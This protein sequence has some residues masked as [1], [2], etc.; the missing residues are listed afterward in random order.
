MGQVE[1]PARQILRRLHQK[2]Y[3]NSAKVRHLEHG[4]RPASAANSLL[5]TEG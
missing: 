5:N 3:A 2:N 1:E 4:D